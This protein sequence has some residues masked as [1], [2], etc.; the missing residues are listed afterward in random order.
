MS[1]QEQEPAKPASESE[2]L[3]QRVFTPKGIGYDVAVENGFATVELEK[4]AVWL[5]PVKEIS[6]VPVECARRAAS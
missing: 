3:F 4:G 2:Y 6:L 1:K 5:G